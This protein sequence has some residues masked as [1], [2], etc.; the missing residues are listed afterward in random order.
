[1]WEAQVRD[2]VEKIARTNK[3]D[4]AGRLPA[5]PP[6]SAASAGIPGPTRE[7]MEAARNIPPSQQDEMVKGM[8]D[9]L[10]TRLQQNPRDENGWMML[11]RSRMVQNDREGAATALRSGLAAFGDDAAVQQRLRTAAGELG[12]P[13]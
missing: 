2:A 7:Q 6:A 8:V 3:I 1:M 9:R 11:M 5:R 10:A 4:I 13:Q 12:I